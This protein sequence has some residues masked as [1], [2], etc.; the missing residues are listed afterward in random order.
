MSELDSSHVKTRVAT[1]GR[2]QR[3]SEASVRTEST[4]APPSREERPAQEQHEGP[5]AL[6][7]MVKQTSGSF[8]IHQSRCLAR[9]WGVLCYNLIRRAK[10]KALAA[11]SLGVGFA[12]NS[13]ILRWKWVQQAKHRTAGKCSKHAAFPLTDKNRRGDVVQLVRTLPS[14]RFGLFSSL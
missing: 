11:L 8:F 12:Q 13:H 2:Q 6:S 5:V 3:L 4:Q 1:L 7:S 14:P 9:D 10:T